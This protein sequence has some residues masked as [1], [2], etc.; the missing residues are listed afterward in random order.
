MY[1]LDIACA[2]VSILPLT[3]SSP[4][5]PGYTRCRDAA[6]QHESSLAADVADEHSLLHRHRSDFVCVSHFLCPLPPPLSRNIH[7]P[8]GLCVCVSLPL[9][10]PPPPPSRVTYICHRDAAAQHE[11]SLSAE[12]ADERFTA[13]QLQAQL[14]ETQ[15][16]VGGRGE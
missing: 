12:L 13:A 4:P 1:I 2:P 5:P 7:L 9:P 14:E 11:S 8:Q 10:P 16:Q 6:A 15:Q 3:A